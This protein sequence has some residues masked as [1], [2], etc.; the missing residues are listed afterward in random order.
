MKEGIMTIVKANRIDLEPCVDIVFA[1]VLGRT[2]YP[3]RDLMREAIEQG[4]QTDEIYLAKGSGVPEEADGDL[5]ILGLVWYQREGM[6]HS[7]PYLHMIV[8]KDGC[9][10]QGIGTELMDFFEQ[11][12]LKNGKNRL[13]TKAFL[14]VG[15]FNSSAEKFYRERGYV[16]LA[17][18]ENLFR[19]GITET[20]MV[21]NVTAPR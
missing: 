8:V 20:L 3:F 19:R 10:G 21:K 14:T 9:R 2:Y 1:S 5:D 4:I 17:E 7:F 6:F 12:I 13:R 18:F 16:R 11:D 15:D